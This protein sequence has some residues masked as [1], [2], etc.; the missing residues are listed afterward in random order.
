VRQG[1]NSRRHDGNSQG[2]DLWFSSLLVPQIL[3]FY[4][5]ERQKRQEYFANGSSILEIEFS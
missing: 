5:D 1:A 2:G 4:E 3:S